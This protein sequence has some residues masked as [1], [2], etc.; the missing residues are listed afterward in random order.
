MMRRGTAVKIHW[1]SGYMGV[2]RN[3]KV[4]EAAKEVAEKSGTR[5]GPERFASLTHVNRTITE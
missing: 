1:I 4:D 2:K 5:R 3:E